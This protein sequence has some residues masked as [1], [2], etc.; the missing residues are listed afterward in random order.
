MTPKWAEAAR[1]RDDLILKTLALQPEWWGKRVEPRLLLEDGCLIWQGAV[2]PRY[3]LVAL[4]EAI[5][6]RV[7]MVKTHRVVYLHAHGEIPY[8][9]TVNH[10]CERTRC[11]EIFHLEAVTQQQ[12]MANA[13]HLM[14]RGTSVDWVAKSE[15][16]VR[17]Q[18]G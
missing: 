16:L 12:N 15:E 10:R 7:V 13:S 11:C 8:G 5:A 2:D 9:W 17:A 14:N 6:G 1:A 18:W 4:P 3:P